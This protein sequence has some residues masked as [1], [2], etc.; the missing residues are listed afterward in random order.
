[1]CSLYYKDDCVHVVAA[2]VFLCVFLLPPYSG[3]GCKHLFKAWETPICGDYSQSGIDIRK[4]TVILKF[5]L[6]ITWEGLSATLDRRRSPQRGVGIWPNHGIKS[7]C[8][9]SIY[10]IRLSSYWVLIFTCVAPM[11]DTHF[12]GAIKWRVLISPYLLIPT[13]F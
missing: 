6:W 5:D 12:K 2:I 4:T 11:F 1:M 8:L 9:L 13:W 10:F 7:P 3:F